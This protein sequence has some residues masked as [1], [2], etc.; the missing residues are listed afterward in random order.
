M[1]VKHFFIW[2]KKHFGSCLKIINSH[3]KE[4]F[5]TV[6]C[7]I[8]TLCIDLNG[9]FHNAAQKIYKY[10]NFAPKNPRLLSKKKGNGL[11]NQLCF[12]KE[13]CEKIEY[14]RNLVNPSKRIVICIDGIAGNAKMAQQRQRRFKTAKNSETPEDFDPNCLTPG[15]KVMDFLSKYIDW[16]IRTMISYSPEWQKLDIIFSDEKTPGEGEHKI[17]NYM[18]E[19]ASDNESICIHGMDADLIMLALSSQR[20]NLYILRE[21][22][23]NINELYLLDISKFNKELSSFM[24]WDSRQEVNVT[25]NPEEYSKDINAPFRPKTAIIDFVFIC[26]LV[27]NDFLPTLPALAILEGG[28]D[29]MID[30]YKDV[31]KA[32]GHLTKISRKDKTQSITFNIQALQVFFGTLAQYEKGFLEE[33]L[34]KINEFISDPL[35]M[36]HSSSKY[37]ADM[38]DTKL[39]FTL[40]FEKYKDEYY[41]RKFPELTSIDTVCKEYIRGMEWVLTYY[42]RGIPDWKWFYPYF[43]GPFL[44]DLTDFL[45]EYTFEAFPRN[46]PVLPFIQ[47]LSVLPPQSSHLLP[48]PCDKIIT[49]EVSPLKNFYPMDFE[50]DCSGKRREWEGIVILPMID[51][52]KL[53]VEYA[54]CLDS[55]KEQDLRR[56]VVKTSKV[57]NYNKKFYKEFKSFYGNIPECKAFISSI[58]I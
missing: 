27:G 49:S 44:C 25:C 35:L 31:G 45:N 47:L 43:Y 18:R 4:N 37:D 26:F 40:N 15:T 42:F 29:S 48:F 34:S 3:Q 30:V 38:N 7:N 23:M 19:F 10:G 12:F 56:N 24:R 2:Y 41:E 21:N 13:V 8:E 54:K 58:D 14:Y 5:E 36:K 28:I 57:Y 11:K 33:K 53:E 6:K 22:M 1:G 32:Y 52:K 39:T 50:V 9:V 16:Y 17:V 46:K 55:I 20:D 51:T